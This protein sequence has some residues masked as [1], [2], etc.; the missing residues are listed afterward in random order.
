MKE[1]VNVKAKSFFFQIE[2]Y[3]KLIRDNYL[4]C[5]YRV[6]IYLITA[7]SIFLSSLFSILPFLI[8]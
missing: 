1:K 2:N 3:F 8:Y 7:Q 5:D 4:T 6:N